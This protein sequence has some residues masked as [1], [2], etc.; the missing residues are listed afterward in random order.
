MKKCID[1][2]VLGVAS[3]LA[4]A[5]LSQAQQSPLPAFSKIATIDSLP[6][7]RFKLS[8]PDGLCRVDPG[9]D[10]EWFENVSGLHS[11]KVLAMWATC[12]DLARIR[13][14]ELVEP[15]EWMIMLAQRGANGAVGPMKGMT[16]EYALSR[17]ADAMSKA[18]A[19][20][21]EAYRSVAEA[22]A[23][24]RSRLNQEL[25]DFKPQIIGP[26]GLAIYIAAAG[27]MT[28]VNTSVQT[29]T[30]SVSGWS[31]ISQYR[32]GVGYNYN[33][34]NAAQLDHLLDEVKGVMS[35]LDQFSR[36]AE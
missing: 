10:R 30:A 33:N 26:D 19:V 8:V 14:G 6:G 20:G 17:W 15:A 9:I 23:K 13:Q 7:V 11:N 22:K 3:M 2:F 1:V 12:S 18:D 32:I 28:D 27:K 24:I 34:G 5:N 25:S 16:R 29:Q 21:S 36:E 4:S 35:S 31:L